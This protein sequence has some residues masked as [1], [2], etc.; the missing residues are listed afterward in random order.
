[1]L[2]DLTEVNRFHQGCPPCLARGLIFGDLNRFRTETEGDRGLDI[3]TRTVGRCDKETAIA[4]GDLQ[5]SVPGRQVTRQKIDF[6]DE[7]R[8]EPVA[9]VPIDF[10]RSADLK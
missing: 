5:Q 8:N 9:R 4:T 1:M 3:W 6:P 2:S 7:L 10:R